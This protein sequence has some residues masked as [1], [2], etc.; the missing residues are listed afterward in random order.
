MS[1]LIEQLT[2][3]FCCLPGVGKKSAQRMVLNLLEKN[4]DGG[5]LLAETL[6]KALQGV[7][8]CESCR[9]FTEHSVCELCSDARRDAS[10]MCI[11]ESPADVIAIEQ[12]KSFKGRYFVLMG[13]LSP[14]DG[15][16]PEQLGIEALI[17]RLKNSLV[18]EVIIATNPTVEGEATA[19]YL[20]E[21]IKELG[22]TVSRIAHGVP[23]GGEL[24][25]VDSNT[26]SHAFSGRK[27][28]E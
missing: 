15:V 4:R 2:Q 11:V 18:Q 21:S 24:E 25:Y 13:H 8:H 10:M 16:G 1:Q 3:A 7:K 22:L 28:F 14:I 27:H 17:Q 23:L 6:I 5:M 26:I 9:N 19:F 12:S 20:S